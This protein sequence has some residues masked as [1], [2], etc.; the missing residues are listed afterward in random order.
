MKCLQSVLVTSVALVNVLV[1]TLIICRSLL[2]VIMWSAVSATWLV[3]G[4]TVMLFPVLLLASSVVT[5]IILFSVR[6]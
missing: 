6:W 2:G 5:L 4:F 3:V 1:F